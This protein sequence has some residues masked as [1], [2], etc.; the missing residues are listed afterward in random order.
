[1]SFMFAENDGRTAEAKRASE[2]AV[3]YAPAAFDMYLRKRAPW[4]RPEDHWSR[5]CAR[6]AGRL[7]AAL[8]SVAAAQSG[9]PMIYTDRNGSKPEELGLSEWLPDYP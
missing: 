9:L 7:E 8:R 6:L 2:K 5:V 4:F 1:L 3:S